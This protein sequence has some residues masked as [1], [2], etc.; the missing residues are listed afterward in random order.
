MTKINEI[1]KMLKEGGLEQRHDAHPQSHFGAGYGD[2]SVRDEVK[3]TYSRLGVGYKV[4]QRS[5][6]TGRIVI[7]LFFTAKEGSKEK[8][9]QI[10]SSNGISFVS[11]LNKFFI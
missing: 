7:E 10:L 8:V 1:R 11:D 9:E 5:V 3:T 4:K 6:K 2:F